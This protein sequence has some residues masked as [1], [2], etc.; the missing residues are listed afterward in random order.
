MIPPLF[1]HAPRP[2]LPEH[3]E[4]ALMLAVALERY[5]CTL[6]EVREDY[7]LGRV[8]R[9]LSG[10]PALQGRVARAGVSTVLL[11]GPDHGPAPADGRDRARWSLYVQDRIE[12]DTGRTADALGVTVRWAER[13][14]TV[15]SAAC[16][17]LLAQT[18]LAD[19]RWTNLGPYAG[20]LSAIQVPVAEAA[21]HTVA[22]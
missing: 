21:E 11:T 7:W 4:F 2:A 9:A 12:A 22:A 8:W 20:D 19:A 10:D 17:P 15:I 5:R 14:V 13:P 3:P 1:S 16:T 18:A 6:G